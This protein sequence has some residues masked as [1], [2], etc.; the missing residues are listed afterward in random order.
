[1]KNRRD[2]G[3]GAEKV[4]TGD[5]RFIEGDENGHSKDRQ[6]EGETALVFPVGGTRVGKGF[7]DLDL[8]QNLFGGEGRLARADKN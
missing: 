3:G 1:M 7:G 8:R 5:G 2:G 4:R 6:V